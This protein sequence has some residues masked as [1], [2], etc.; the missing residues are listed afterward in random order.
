[1]KNDTI[2]AISTP[3]GIGGIGLIRLSGPDTYRIIKK[4]FMSKNEKIPVSKWKSHTVR[5]G[6]IVDNEKIVDE[7]LITIMRKPKSYTREDMAEIGCHGGLAAM[8]SVLNL[9]LSRGA[10]LA[11]P[12]EFTKRA[13]L[14]G[15]IDIAQAESVMNI[16][17]S[18]TEKSL[19]VSIKQLKGS[20][21]E[22]IQ[23]L[24][25]GI[26]KLLVQLETL[27]DFSEEHVVEE[28]KPDIE[29][30]IEKTCNNIE[31]ILKSGQTGKIFTEGIKAAIVGK[32]NVGKSSL[33]N[34]LTEDEKALVSEIPGTTRDAIES[35]ISI[36]G[37]PLKIIDTAGIRK[38]EGKIEVMGVD[39]AR[40]WMEK[41]EIVLLLLDGS[42]TLDS[43]D[44]DL[45]ERSG[46]K[47][48]ILVINKIDLPLKID[49]KRLEKF[50]DNKEVVKIS[51]ATGH[52][53]SMLYEKIYELIESGAGTLK[54]PEFFLNLRQETI[55]KNVLQNLTEAKK[56]VNKNLSLDIIAE[57]IKFCLWDMDNITGKNLSDEIIDSIFDKF[58]IGK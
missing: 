53:I 26:F 18:Q 21:S 55:L 31:N 35:I 8:K 57:Q 1:M 39:K 7:V 4:I 54:E 28:I 45:L 33:L 50:A 32:P 47:R 56:A 16:I 17:L 34:I 14:N 52:G 27:I 3:L 15:R 42:Q 49:E 30:T 38:P 23:K 22:K 51:A 25:D 5:Y 48:R 43:L 24:R 11:S 12:G 44:M 6:Y 41:A 20:L 29:G 10:R 19:E 9:C 36:K 37:I 13:F 58:C 40:L 46:E 2:C